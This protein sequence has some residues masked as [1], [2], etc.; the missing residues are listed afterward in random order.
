MAPLA[1]AFRREL[2]RQV[3]ELI[4]RHVPSFR[5]RPPADRIA[6]V[7]RQFEAAV[8]HGVRMQRDAA[9]WAAAA[10]VH[11]EDFLTALGLNEP[12]G[13]WTLA[14]TAKEKGEILE[15]ILKMPARRS[16]AC[17]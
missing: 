14:G 10:A 13:A 17:R 11:G 8:E 3:A 9:R 12:E 4:S 7:L 15:G 5:S 2:A 6:F 1:A 16:D